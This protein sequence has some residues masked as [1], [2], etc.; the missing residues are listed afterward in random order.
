MGEKDLLAFGVAGQQINSDNAYSAD[1]LFEKNLKGAGV[2]YRRSG[3]HQ[4]RWRRPA[5]APQREH[6]AEP[7]YGQWLQS[8]DG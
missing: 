2:D 8:S 5:M 1:G 7:G 6:G 3:I 4:V